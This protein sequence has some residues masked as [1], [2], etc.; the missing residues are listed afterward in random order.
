MAIIFGTF[1]P[2]TLAGGAQADEIYGFDGNDSL[3]GGDGADT[4]VGGS[5]VD[6]MAGGAG[7]D[8]YY[9]DDARDL[10]QENDP[11]GGLV[12]TSVSYSLASVS[13]T[14][15]G[16]TAA[17]NEVRAIPGTAPIDLTGTDS[18]ETLTG[19]DAANRIDGGNAIYSTAR[20]PA[21]AGRR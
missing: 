1:A 7:Y 20:H 3:S 12:I 6:T 15:V 2:D 10:I 17:I 21:G 4:M 19:N 11:A 8:I 18:P 13:T 5:G 9:V 16:V 14:Y